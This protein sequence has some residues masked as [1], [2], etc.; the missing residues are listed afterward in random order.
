MGGINTTYG[1][2]RPVHD[3]PDPF[4][5]NYIE[6]GNEDSFSSSSNYRLLLASVNF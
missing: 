2:L 1:S 3:H 6:I 5:I 4:Q